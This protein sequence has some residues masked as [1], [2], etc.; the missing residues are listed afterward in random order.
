MESSHSHGGR[1]RQ[2]RSRRVPVG[3]EIAALSSFLNPAAAHHQ[4]I[5]VENDGLTG[6]HGPLRLIE[7]DRHRS[8]VLSQQGRLGCLMPAANLSLNPQGPGRLLNGDPID[9]GGDQAGS[10]QIAVRAHH[11]PIA[12]GVGLEDVKPLPG[13]HSQS[14]PLADG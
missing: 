6:G 7:A 12:A 5:L 11:H 9:P 2:Q 13:S 14:L 1:C 10:E 3:Q 4:V 8:V